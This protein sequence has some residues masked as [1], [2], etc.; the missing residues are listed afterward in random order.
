MPLISI[1]FSMNKVVLSAGP[2]LSDRLRKWQTKLCN[3][4]RAGLGPTDTRL[5]AQRAEPVAAIATAAAK[6]WP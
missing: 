5:S 4:L 3:S 1:R 2:C 6:D